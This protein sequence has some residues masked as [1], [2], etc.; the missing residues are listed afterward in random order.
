MAAADAAMTTRLAT[1]AGIILSI[2]L[3]LHLISHLALLCSNAQV[4][5]DLFGRTKRD[6]CAAPIMISSGD[7]PTF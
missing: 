2:S 6:C 7:S 3:I 4:A 1:G 5:Y